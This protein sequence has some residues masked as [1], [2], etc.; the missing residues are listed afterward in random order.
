CDVFGLGAILCEVLTGKPPYDGAGEELRAQAQL[1][2][3]MPAWA[4]LGACGADEEL[5]G[6][7]RSYLGMRPE[8]RPADA[9]AGAV[10][11]YQAGVRER[12]RKAELERLAA[13]TRMSEERKRRRVQLA[14]AAAVLALVAAGAGAGLLLQRHAR[15]DDEQRQAVS[16]ALQR[17]AELR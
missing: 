1:G 15:R 4:R 16:I 5:V 2:N 3:L 8:E 11:A 12:L 14:L 9:A 13:E 10:A 6:L 7:A 17:A